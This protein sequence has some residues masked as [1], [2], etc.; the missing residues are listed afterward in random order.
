MRYFDVGGHRV[1]VLV[2]RASDGLGLYYSSDINNN[3][4]YS[5]DYNSKNNN[6][7]N[8]NI[9]NYSINNKYNI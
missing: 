3:N 4:N 5:Y 7:K 1:V 8:N 2:V 6:S 9:H